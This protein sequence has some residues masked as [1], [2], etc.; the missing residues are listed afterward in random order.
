[1]TERSI[2]LGSPTYRNIKILTFLR[3]GTTMDNLGIINV[4]EYTYISYI[5]CYHD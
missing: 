1:M 4:D 2:F 5:L 3:V